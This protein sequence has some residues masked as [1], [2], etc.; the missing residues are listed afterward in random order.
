M[1]KLASH[2]TINKTKPDAKRTAEPLFVR[3]PKLFSRTKATTE[4]KETLI[5]KPLCQD[6]QL[7]LINDCS[8]LTQQSASS[9]Q[10]T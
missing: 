7:G 4:D 2:S 1:L 6:S 9:C 8:L 5:N 3:L 10:A